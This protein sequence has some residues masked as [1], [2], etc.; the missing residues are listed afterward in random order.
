M[1]V[2]VFFEFLVVEAHV[3][4]CI[5]VGASLELLAVEELVDE[6]RAVEDWNHIIFVKGG[7]SPKF[8][9]EHC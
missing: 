1:I 8:S 7:L 6:G 4:F 9:Y 3:G 5:E 2:R